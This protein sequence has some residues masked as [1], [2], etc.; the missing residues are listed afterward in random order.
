MQV[1]ALKLDGGGSVA[2]T[3]VRQAY[4][5][6]LRCF[7][8][9]MRSGAFVRDLEAGML[10][11]AGQ[12]LSR[13][14]LI[15]IWENAGKGLPEFVTFNPYDLDAN[16]DPVSVT[17]AN[18]DTGTG[19]GSGGAAAAAAAAAGVARSIAAAAAAI[20]VTPTSKPE[21]GVG[22][23]EAATTATVKET[24]K[25]APKPELKMV[26]QGPDT[27]P[28]SKDPDQLVGKQI[29]RL[30]E[31]HG[32]F[33]GDVATW[34]KATGV[35]EVLFAKGT[36]QEIQERMNL[37]DPPVPVS[38]RD[39]RRLV[40]ATAAAIAQQAAQSQFAAGARGIHA[41][42]RGGAKSTFSRRVDLFE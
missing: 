9:Y 7:E 16:G 41:S 23:N 17:A 18:A 30:W 31:G 25:S 29:W 8:L 35:H 3:N 15:R 38:W 10:P 12:A 5:K 33:P 36:P 2:T 21:S 28:P 39:P 27:T 11:P 20:G 4:D 42:A 24:P 32:W 26:P 19:G 34:D 40:S 37:L 6:S 14:Q 1:K 13:T 22:K